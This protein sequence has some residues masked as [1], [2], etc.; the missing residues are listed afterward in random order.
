[1]STISVPSKTASP[2][3]NQVLGST[4]QRRVEEALLEE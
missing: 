2:L 3:K 1:M 4:Q